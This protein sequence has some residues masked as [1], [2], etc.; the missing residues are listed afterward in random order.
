VLAEHGDEPLA[1]AGPCVESHPERA[2][3]AGQ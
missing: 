1:G 2:I 3:S